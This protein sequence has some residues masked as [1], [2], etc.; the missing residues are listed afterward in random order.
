M[1]NTGFAVQGDDQGI[2]Q[3]LRAAH[4]AELCRDSRK[5]RL[6]C[7]TK[8]GTPLAVSVVQ[9]GDGRRL[10]GVRRIIA[11]PR[12]EQI[13]EDVQGR[14]SAWP[15]SCRNLK[16]CSMI[17]GR[18]RVDVQIRDEERGHADLGQALAGSGERAR[19][20]GS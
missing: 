19:S 10:R 8:Q 1:T 4:V 2:G 7:M 18:A 12:F 20:S 13:A 14:G 5:S 16:N 9:S 3:Q 6:P 11:D 15:R 17:A